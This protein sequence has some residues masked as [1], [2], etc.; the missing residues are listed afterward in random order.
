MPAARVPQGTAEIGE[1]RRPACGL[2]R[3]AANIR[4]SSC[5]SI[6]HT[7]PDVR[8]SRRVAGNHRRAVCAPLR[9]PL[10]LLQVTQKSPA[11]F[12]CPCGTGH[13]IARFPLSTEVL[14]Y[15]RTGHQDALFLGVAALA[16][17]WFTSPM[18]LETLKRE[19]AALDDGARRE[20]CSF[21]FSLREKQWAERLREMAS[22]LDDPN[23]NRWLTLD[24]VRDRLE[25]IP[26]PAGE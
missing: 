23:P 5:A 20:L 13:C 12:C 8:H 26:E 10:H 21:L 7:R 2:R 24:E 11:K 3:P 19:I 16:G 4:T 15:F 25:K 1:H 9:S 18:S 6:R 17:L 14:G 22:V